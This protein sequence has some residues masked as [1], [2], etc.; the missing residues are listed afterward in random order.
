MGYHCP[1]SHESG[2][3]RTQSNMVR[4]VNEV[5]AHCAAPLATD[6]HSPGI[7]LLSCPRTLVATRVPPG[8]R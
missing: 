4:P 8:G 7:R 2:S 3:F 5:C 6:A 1:Q